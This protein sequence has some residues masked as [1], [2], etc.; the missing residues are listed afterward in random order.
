MIFLSFL[1]DRPT[2]PFKSSVHLPVS[3]PLDFNLCWYVGDLISSLDRTSSTTIFKFIWL[4]RNHLGFLYPFQLILLKSQLMPIAS[5]H[6]KWGPILDN[7]FSTTQF[8]LERYQ[9]AERSILLDNLTFCKEE[10]Y[11]VGYELCWWF[12]S[13]PSSTPMNCNMEP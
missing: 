6:Q 10:V 1:Q 8:S 13:S 3:D 7:S 2:K 9:P 11:P 12:L 5:L 4:L